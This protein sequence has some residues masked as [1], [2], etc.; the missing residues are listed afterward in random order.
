MV[1]LFFLND[2][3]IEMKRPWDLNALK[4]R[5]VFLR[6]KATNYISADSGC[7]LAWN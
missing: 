5:M 2:N 1:M 3:H 4:V 6:F 7:L